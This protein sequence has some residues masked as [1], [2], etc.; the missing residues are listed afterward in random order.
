MKLFDINIKTKLI[1]SF[2]ILIIIIALIG[3]GEY[4]T[5]TMLNKNRTEIQKSYEVADAIMELKYHLRIKM[6]MVMEMLQAKSVNELEDYYEKNLAVNN[7]FNVNIGFLSKMANDKNWGEDFADIKVKLGQIAKSIGNDNKEVISSNIALLNEKMQDLLVATDRQSIKKLELELAEI[8]KLIDKK[9]DDL[10]LSLE[11]IENEVQ[12]VVEGSK[13]LSESQSLRAKNVIFITFIIALI[14][15]FLAE[16]IIIRNITIPLKK[17]IVFAKKIASGDLSAELD[18]NQKDEIGKFIDHIK[19]MVETFK[20]GVRIFTSIAEGKILKTAHEFELENK[21]GD[22]D[23]AL[24][25]ML[26]SL[27]ISIQQLNIISEGKISKAASEIDKSRNGDLERAINMMIDKLRESVDI[28]RQVANGNLVINTENLNKENELDS[29]LKS[30]IENLKNIVANIKNGSDNI[31]G[32]SQQLSAAAQQLSQGASEQASSTE[33]VS[34]SMEEM[35]SNIQQNTDN[36]KKT[37]TISLQASESIRTIGDRS[38][39]SLDS[40]K[41]ISEKITIINDIAFQTNILALN[42]AVEAA[43]AGEHGKGFAVVAAE[44]R[45]L[46]E[47]SKIAAS[48][49][50]DLAK[51]T[52]SITENSVQMIESTIPEIQ[53]TAT[54]IQEITAAS[55]EQ[56]SGAT[57]VNSAVLQLSQVTQ[58]SSATSEELSTSAEELYSQAEQLNELISFFKVEND[59]HQ[60]SDRKE[61]SPKKRNIPNMNTETDPEKQITDLPIRNKADHDFESF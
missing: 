27:K 47:R 22:F 56:N 55:M 43:R 5:L 20:N 54:L 13:V 31:S 32:A 30:M 4:S 34:S 42:A 7:E 2:S 36:S 8:D 53:K 26:D 21:N 19:E 1:T 24:K 37:E 12:K 46:A 18:L 16:I 29:S 58:Q 15:S 52:V 28:A 60:T 23:K 25:N 3:I 10:S 48:D 50:I 6:Q 40:I 41:N 17:G 45:K 11:D 49:I 61:K 9:G 51:S 33:E 59:L 14:I 44:V 39:E 35:V 57:Q 38:R